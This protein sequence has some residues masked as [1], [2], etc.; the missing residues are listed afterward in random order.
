MQPI[1]IDSIGN[2]LV[3]VSRELK[4]HGWA[5]ICTAAAGHPVQFTIGLA[6][7]WKHPEL[8]VIGLTPDLG[9]VVLER[10]VRRIKAGERLRAGDFFSD[11]LKGYDLFIVENP[12]EPEGPPLTGGRLRVIWPDAKHRYPWQPECE[13]MCSAQSL[14]LEPDGLNLDGL[15]ALFANAKRLS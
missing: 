15:E 12:V 9:E 4:Q 10:L 1:H 3:Q 13:P 7:R 2:L 11:V 14:L 8:E 5:L 6:A